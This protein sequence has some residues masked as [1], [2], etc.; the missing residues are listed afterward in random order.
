[1]SVDQKGMTLV[2]PVAAGKDQALSNYILTLNSAR[3]FDD[4]SQLHFLS[5]TVLPA[6]EESQPLLLVIEFNIDQSL[7]NFIKELWQY[8]QA[9]IQALL[10]YCEPKAPKSLTELIALFNKYD[11]GGG[12][13]FRALRGANVSSIRNTQK[14]FAA[15]KAWIE[16]AKNGAKNYLYPRDL[17]AALVNDAGVKKYLQDLPDLWPGS[18]LQNVWL[19]IRVIISFIF[20]TL[21]LLG[22]G[23]GYISNTGTSLFQ[24]FALFWALI[25]LFAVMAIEVWFR[26]LN[27]SEA[28][29][30]K[31]YVN[32]GI[33]ILAGIAVFVTVFE[34]GQKS[35]LASLIWFLV[36]LDLWVAGLAISLNKIRKTEHIEVYVKKV[37]TFFAIPVV[38][39]LCIQLLG[40]PDS[41]IAAAILADL[42]FAAAILTGGLVLVAVVVNLFRTLMVAG[43]AGAA[44]AGF[45]LLLTPFI[46]GQNS[47]VMY[48]FAL[49]FTLL[50][51]V[52]AY[53]MVRAV[54]EL[55]AQEK[56]DCESPPIWMP[57]DLRDKISKQESSNHKAQNHLIS[58]TTI[59]PGKLRY[60]ALR[61]VLFFT[62]LT[63]AL[64]GKRGELSGITTIHF[65]RW[66]IID[67]YRLLFLTNYYGTWDSYLDEFIDQASG[68]LTGIWTNTVGFPRSQ[69]LN[70]GGAKLEQRFKIYARR[71]Q[72]QTLYHYQ[73]YPDLS[74]D[75]IED[76]LKLNKI[77]S[78]E[79]RTDADCEAVL[80]M[81]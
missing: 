72:V 36:I 70:G 35:L 7:D 78:N 49:I 30:S 37:A 69:W 14:L 42:S 59:K 31:K 34:I 80:R 5:M 47:V 25:L 20:T 48:L 38:L 74:V 11:K 64:K 22:S 16:N 39:L 9:T 63:I 32:A 66:L 8:S 26:D 17:C 2:I 3:A 51:V 53:A 24:G 75:Q 77:L 71:S 43:S 12:T 1:M 41:P 68:G 21:I 13:Y 76:H 52:V 6:S 45:A 40:A 61:L 79:D 65:A 28:V 67:K 33:F 4:L 19:Q 23:L 58:Y 73:A 60:A 50:V 27:K 57:G 55:E 44:G 62:G 29:N 56:Q 81:L 46:A 54:C 18:C 15:A 10:K